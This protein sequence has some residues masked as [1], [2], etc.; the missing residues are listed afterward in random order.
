M[1]HAYFGL[2][3]W[4]MGSGKPRSPERLRA[5]LKEAGFETCREY[6]TRRPLMVRALVAVR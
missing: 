5:M 3:L 2:Y 6:P 1:G 4:A